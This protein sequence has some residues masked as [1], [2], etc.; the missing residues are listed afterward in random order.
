MRLSNTADRGWVPRHLMERSA[1]MLTFIDNSSGHSGNS[2]TSGNSVN[3]FEDS[4]MNSGQTQPTG[5]EAP[6]D[7]RAFEY[8]SDDV[9]NI[10]WRQDAGAFAIAS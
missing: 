1:A 3:S 4:G 6:W 9:K 10:L 2:T 7:M 8:N 5:R